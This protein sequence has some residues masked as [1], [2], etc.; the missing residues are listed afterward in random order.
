MHNGVDN[1]YPSRGPRA[2]VNCEVGSLGRRHSFW[3]IKMPLSWADLY[4]LWDSKL[5]DS[6]HYI[7]CIKI[8]YESWVLSA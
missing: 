4:V 8:S 2:E 7:T 6:N 5:C 3:S 1:F